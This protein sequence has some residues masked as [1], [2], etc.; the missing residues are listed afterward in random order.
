M[1]GFGFKYPPINR[2]PFMGSAWSVSDLSNLTLWLDATDTSTI[3][4]GSPINGDPVDTW[5]DKSTAGSDFTQSTGTLQPIWD[6]TG[7]GSNSLAQVN[8]DASNDYVN[9]AARVSNSSSG[10]IAFVGTYDSTP[11]VNVALNLYSG[12]N[13]N[14]ILGF[15]KSGNQVYWQITNASS[16]TDRWVST[17]TTLVNGNDYIVEIWG[18]TSTIY[19]RINGNTQT[20]SKTL[21]GTAAAYLWTNAITTV[22][23]S[24]ISRSATTQFPITLSE[25]II[26][27]SLPSSG[28]RDTTLSYL[29]TKYGIY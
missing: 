9:V 12:G 19:M 4:L 18:D 1:F 23:L 10:Y 15:L 11:A 25:L 26:T 17:T 2:T 6:S 16:Q 3:N 8:P 22:T 20:V 27:D 13:E 28:D 21:A 7:M 14:I 5:L 24:Q 29:N